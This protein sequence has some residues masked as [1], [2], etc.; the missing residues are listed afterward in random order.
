MKPK[1]N[2]SIAL[3]MLAG[4][5]FGVMSPR[6]CRCVLRRSAHRDFLWAIRAELIL[7]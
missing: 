5:P 7:S 3:P 4:L 1:K 6:F 2:E